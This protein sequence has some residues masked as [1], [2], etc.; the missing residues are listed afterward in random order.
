MS[1]PSVQESFLNDHVGARAYFY[2][3]I[4][5]DW[6]DYKS[7]EILEQ[8]VKAMTPGYSK[9]LIH[10][11]IVPDTGASLTHVML[12]M[13]M[14]CFNGGIERT[15][16]HWRQLLEKAGLEVVK[17]WPGPEESA[18]GLVEA[19]LKEPRDSNS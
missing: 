3:H 10:E 4:F 12:D 1:Y 15:A 16:Q 2:H 8:V 17:I 14:M 13:V 19:V 6:S 18:A 5:H 7:L 9:L 11:M